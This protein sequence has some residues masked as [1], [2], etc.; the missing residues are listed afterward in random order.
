MDMGKNADALVF[1]RKE[2]E[3]DRVCMG[4]ELDY[5]RGDPD[6]AENIVRHLENMVLA[7]R[8]EN[9]ALDKEGPVSPK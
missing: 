6:C 2:L 8:L 4:M 1:A 9:M 7:E 3:Q 5:L